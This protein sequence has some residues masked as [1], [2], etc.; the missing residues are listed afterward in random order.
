VAQLTLTERKAVLLVLEGKVRVDHTDGLLVYGRVEGKH[1]TYT[2]SVDPEGHHCDCQFGRHKSLAHSH[3]L[4][5]ELMAETRM[6]EV[7]NG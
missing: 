6:L 5:L 4:A 2:V 1:G 3:T 7:A